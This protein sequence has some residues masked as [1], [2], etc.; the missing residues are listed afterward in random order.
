MYIHV[1]VCVCVCVSVCVCV[2]VYVCVCVCVW[3]IHNYITVSSLKA[4][5]IAH[6]KSNS[7]TFGKHTIVLQKELAKN[8]YIISM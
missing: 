3:T 8:L 7:L 4:I 5:T 2:C 6:S 1:C